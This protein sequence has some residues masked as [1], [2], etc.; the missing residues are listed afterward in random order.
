MKRSS[1]KK[2]FYIFSEFKLQMTSKPLLYACSNST[3]SNDKVYKHLFYLI[4]SDEELTLGT[5]ALY[6]L[7]WPIYIFNLVDITKLSIYNTLT[8]YLLH[9]NHIR[10]DN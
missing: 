1:F 4:R 9:F 6:S 3:E 7:R 2:T 5:S 10:D 8:L